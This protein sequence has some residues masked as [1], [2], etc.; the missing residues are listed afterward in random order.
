MR[1]TRDWQWLN[2]LERAFLLHYKRNHS[3]ANNINFNSKPQSLTL[4]FNRRLNNWKKCYELKTNRN[5]LKKRFFFLNKNDKKQNTD[6]FYCW[7]R[8]G[9]IT[10]LFSNRCEF[11]WTLYWNTQISCY[12][13]VLNFIWML[14]DQGWWIV[15]VET[16]EL[17]SVQFHQLVIEGCW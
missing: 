6:F 8:N 7:H 12:H 9:R 16:I 3:A 17:S 15:K 4:I 14:L 2:L 11:G 13:C 10:S 5:K 1:W